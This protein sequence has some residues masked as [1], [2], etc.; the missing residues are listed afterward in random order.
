MLATILCETVIF[1]ISLYMWIKQNAAYLEAAADT[2]TIN[3]SEAVRELCTMRLPSPS[4]A[5][6]LLGKATMIWAWEESS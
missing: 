1:S 3:I 6:N 4:L 5:R 2:N